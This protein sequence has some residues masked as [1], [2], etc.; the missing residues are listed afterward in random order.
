VFLLALSFTISLH[1]FLFPSTRLAN[2]NANTKGA[3]YFLLC[4]VIASVVQDEEVVEW[5]QASALV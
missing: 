2:A 4:A 1:N 3:R 5:S